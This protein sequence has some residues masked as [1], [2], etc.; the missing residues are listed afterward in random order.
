M[1]GDAS[2]FSDLCC[3]FSH[4]LLLGGVMSYWSTTVLLHRRRYF[5]SVQVANFL[6]PNGFSCAPWL[7]F[8]IGIHIW[9]HRGVCWEGLVQ[10]F[11]FQGWHI[12]GNTAPGA[13]GERNCSLMNT[14]TSVIRT[15]RMCVQSFYQ[16]TPNMKGKFCQWLFRC[17]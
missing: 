13:K 10:L 3:R 2:T 4:S 16:L 12:G 11:S 14:G 17:P 8:T 5:L 7:A 9:I 1:Q 6:F 15:G